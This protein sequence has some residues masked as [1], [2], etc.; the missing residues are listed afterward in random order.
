MKKLILI[1]LCAA[2]MTACGGDKPVEERYVY[3]GEKVVD[4]DTGDEYV[5]EDDDVVT[6]IHTDG[7]RET[8]T[9]EET[10]FYGTTV[11]DEYFAELSNQLAGRKEKIL[12]EK[13]NKLKA[14]RRAKYEALS[15]EELMERFKESHQKGED[16]GKQ[17]EMMSELVERG[18]VGTE[19]A[20]NLLEV[21]MSEINFEPEVADVSDP[22]E[23]N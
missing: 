9:A 15:D 20:P 12:E 2:V 23:K 4:V 8:M 11:S 18:V 3:E 17:M 21:P 22:R 13:K 10:P 5:L 16:M 19:D 1:A 7:T 6:V 14:E